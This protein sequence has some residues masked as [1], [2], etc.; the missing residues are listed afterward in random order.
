MKRCPKC[1][2]TYESDELNYCLDDGSPLSPMLD[3]GAPTIAMASGRATAEPVYDPAT[4]VQP[5]SGPQFAPQPQVPK[6]TKFWPF[7]IIGLGILLCGG[8]IG[9]GL[10][11]SKISSGFALNNAVPSPSATPGTRSTSSPDTDE[12][13]LRA[14]TG[15]ITMENF[16]KIKTG[17]SRA[18]VEALLGGKGKQISST[19]GGGIT[20]TVDQWEGENYDSIILSFDNDKVSFKSQAG[21]DF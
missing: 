15:K 21:L 14:G 12:T 11:V 1:F 17:M 3:Q 5:S 20:Y 16:N 10:L 6:K 13:P 18:D 4:A 2:K 7:L 19:T 8:G 9:G